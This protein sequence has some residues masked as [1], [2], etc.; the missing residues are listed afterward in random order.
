MIHF[1]TYNIN[2]TGT[3]FGPLS[4]LPEVDYLD[5]YLL[6]D[7]FG[8]STIMYTGTANGNGFY[9][10]SNTSSVSSIS[11]IVL[12]V[13]CQDIKSTITT[14]NIVSA[15]IDKSDSKHIFLSAG[16]TTRLVTWPITGTGYSNKN[17]VEFNKDSLFFNNKSFSLNLTGDFSIFLVWKDNNTSFGNTIPFGLYTYSNTL[18]SELIIKN[19]YYTEKQGEWGVRLYDGGFRVD[20]FNGLLSTENVTLWEYIHTDI[21]ATSGNNITIDTTN[22]PVTGS[23]FI[24][25]DITL[26]GSGLGYFRGND[27]NFLLGEILLFDRKLSISE[28]TYIYNYFS[29]R[30]NLN[31]YQE[32]L[33]YTIQLTGGPLNN[34]SY[35][36]YS[37]LTSVIN[38]PIQSCVTKMVIDLSNFDISKSKINKIAYSFNNTETTITSKIVDNTIVFND[39]KF[40]FLIVPSENKT[41]ETYYLYLSVYRYDSTI[42]KLILSGDLLK[43]GIR[44]LYKNTK[45]LDAQILDNSKE[46]L[47]VSENNEDKNV[48]LNKLNV[49]IPIQSLSGGEVEPLI[50]VDFVDNEEVIFLLDL[51]ADN[52]VKEKFTKPFFIPVPAP[53]TNPIRPE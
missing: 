7:L 29:S 15:F 2:L 37:L 13:D 34:F 26:S 36:D 4:S 23:Y 43:C 9:Q 16:T 53:R 11:G 17:C 50:N 32:N 38:I 35:E 14:N 51:I 41:I 27:N 33:L 5:S 31:L 20:S 24:D 22:I 42:N 25:N 48:F 39:N 28:K 44:D 49:N 30:W 8:N 10:L 40:S 12:W 1:N 18:T 3:N 19:N 6:A 47:L 52:I 45:L 21:I 46:L